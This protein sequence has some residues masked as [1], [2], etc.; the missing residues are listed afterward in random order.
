MLPTLS[1]THVTITNSKRVTGTCIFCC[2]KI[3]AIA[4]S[5]LLKK[6]GGALQWI[7]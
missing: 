5:V 6:K 2:A 3:V 1:T 7:A 4:S